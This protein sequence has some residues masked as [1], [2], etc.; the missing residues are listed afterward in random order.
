MQMSSPIRDNWFMRGACTLL[1]TDQASP[2]KIQLHK[3]AQGLITFDSIDFLQNGFSTVILLIW[4]T[5]LLTCLVCKHHLPSDFR[6][7]GAQA[8]H[9]QKLRL[10][11]RNYHL[12]SMMLKISVH[13]VILTDEV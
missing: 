12:T 11:Q 3:Y 7:P 13:R 8:I 6:A 9:V 2:S 5:T 4:A 10:F 1:A